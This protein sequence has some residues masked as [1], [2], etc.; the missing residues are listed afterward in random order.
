MRNI[1]HNS[2]NKIL[3][4]GS[5]FAL[6]TLITGGAPSELG[7]CTCLPVRGSDV[8]PWRDDE[9]KLGNRKLRFGGWDKS[10]LTC[11]KVRV[12]AIRRRRD[13]PQCAQQF[14]LVM[15]SVK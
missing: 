4:F 10:A 11:S 7:H 6:K 14:V 13:T 9:S 5:I 3:N 1:L 2:G 8:P 12:V 15:L